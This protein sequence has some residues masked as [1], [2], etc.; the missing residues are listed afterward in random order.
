MVLPV[1]MP[2]RP[3]LYSMRD[4]AGY[5]ASAIIIGLTAVLGLLTVTA[6]LGL[7]AWP[8]LALR[9][10]D[11]QPAFAGA[12]VQ[13][14]LLVLFVL[15]SLYLPA[16]RRVSALEVGHRSFRIALEDVARAY[17]IAHGSDRAGVFALSAEFESVRQ[18]MDMLRRHPDL[19]HLEPE[20]LELAAT[21]SHQSRDL[22]RVYSDEKVDRARRFLRQRQEEAEALADRVKLARAT[23]DELRAW[24]TDV[25]AEERQSHLQIRRLEADLREMLPMLGLDL[26]EPR[27]KNSVVTLPKPGK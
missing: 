25:E 4:L 12:A 9:F 20:L 10:G 7:T 21:M 22:A 1:M 18:R 24:L 19:G 5:V 17:R 14:G 16:L 8:D 13:V 27:S 6:F 3:D 23:C 15:L 2:V 11:W 26:A